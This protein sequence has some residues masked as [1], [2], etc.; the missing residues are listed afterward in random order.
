MRERSALIRLVDVAATDVL[1]FA[2][3]TVA[4]A[5]RRADELSLELL[6]P[7]FDDRTRR[8]RE[9][10]LALGGD[11]FGLDADTA[12]YAL[13][14]AAFF[15]RFY[16]RTE[17]HGLEHLPEGRVLLIANHSGQVP[18][19][20]LV[21][22][23]T[24]FLDAEPPRVIRAMVEKWTQTLP[25]V[26]T[27][28]SRVGQVVGVPENARRLLEMGEPLLVFP[29]GTRGISKPF[30]QRYQLT[31]FGLGFMR[32]AIETNTPIVPIAVVGAEEQY[33]NLGNLR[34]AARALG[35]PVFPVVPQFF[36]PGMQ[37]PL[38]VKYRLWFGEPMRFTGDPD[39]ED[40]AIEEKVF[41]VQQTIQRMIDR[42]LRERKG[43]FR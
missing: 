27:F 41:V 14:A 34:W 29:E 17:V 30:S 25:F 12:K 37:L 7:D 10:Y 38:P 22:G 40:A 16:F 24:L 8:L 20:G 13:V 4:R 15:H 31:E 43:L 19:D 9:R 42:G 32:L 18:L 11:P 23:A 33:V 21:I 36:V 39:D 28:F 1:P 35:M 26:S 5:L 6:G 2:Q 3:R